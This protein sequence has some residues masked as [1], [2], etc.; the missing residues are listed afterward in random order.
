MRQTVIEIPFNEWSRERLRRGV[1]RATARRK[2][3]GDPGDMFRAVGRWWILTEVR[4]VTLR[5]VRD[6]WWKAEGCDSPEEF[7]KVWRSIHP[8][9]GF[10]PNQKVWI[11]FF[12]TLP[13]RGVRL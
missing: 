10:V 12:E 3:Y 9:R 1:K 8:R 13:T 4:R 6:R 7:E 2:R 11:H 5:E